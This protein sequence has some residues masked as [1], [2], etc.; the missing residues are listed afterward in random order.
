M[1][2]TCTMKDNHIEAV[3]PTSDMTNT[4]YFLYPDDG[5]WA[6]WLEWGDCS[7]S[8][9]GGLRERLRLCDG[10]YH[11]GKDCVG[12]NSDTETCAEQA[13]PGE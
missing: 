13:C 7:T 10:P 9:G 5:V 3:L 1:C 4:M 11:G 6:A 8:C 2:I 12:S